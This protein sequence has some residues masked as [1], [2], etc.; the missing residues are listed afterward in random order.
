MELKISRSTMFV[1]FT[2]IFVLV[3]VPGLLYIASHISLLGGTNGT[4]I[5]GID[6]EK[7]IMR[8]EP[9]VYS[10]NNTLDPIG[11][12]IHN[13]E[14]TNHTVTLTLSDNGKSLWQQSYRIPPHTELEIHNIIDKKGVYTL[15]LRTESGESAKHRVSFDRDHDYLLADIKDSNVTIDQSVN[16]HPRRIAERF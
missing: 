16:V 5:G 3:I 13:Y 7:R 8:D 12:H 10:K 2:F 14:N 1:I 6:N 15:T 9:V 4:G 11:I